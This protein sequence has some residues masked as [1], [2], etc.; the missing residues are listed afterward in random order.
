LEREIKLLLKGE[1]KPY[2]WAKQNYNAGWD[3]AIHA[4]LR[5]I[6]RDRKESRG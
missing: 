5:L 1:P 3:Q 6:E 2:S 4:I